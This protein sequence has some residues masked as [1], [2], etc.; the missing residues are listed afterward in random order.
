[1]KWGERGNKRVLIGGVCDVI[2]LSEFYT[3]VIVYSVT[4][5]RQDRDGK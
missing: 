1:L 4:F 3:P 2:R 5:G